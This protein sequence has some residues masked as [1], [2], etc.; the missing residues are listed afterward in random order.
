MATITT[1]PRTGAF[2]GQEVSTNQNGQGL[3][4][5]RA[6]GTMLQHT[7][8]SQA[9]TFTSAKQLSSWIRRNYNY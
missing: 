3:F 9:P 6:D 5:R 8:T 4:T 7:G 2:K 1:T